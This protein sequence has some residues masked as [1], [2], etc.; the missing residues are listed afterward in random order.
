MLLTSGFA[1]RYKVRVTQFVQHWLPTDRATDA[2]Q[3]NDMS[4]VRT[5]SACFLR[6]L[7]IIGELKIL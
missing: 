1:L 5:N 4:H 6:T 2:G 7:K 3:T